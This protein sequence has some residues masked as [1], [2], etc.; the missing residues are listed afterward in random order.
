MRLVTRSPLLRALV[1]SVLFGSVIL[2]LLPAVE[3]DSSRVDRLIRQLGSEKFEERE[4]AS[5]ALQAIGEPALTSL[6]RAAT[7]SGDA[8]VRRRAKRLGI[9]LAPAPLDCTGKDG[10][11]PS[12]VRRDQEA[13]ARFLGRRAEEPVEVAGGVK[14]TFV[15]VPPGKFLMGSPKAGKRP[16]QPDPN[17]M[18]FQERL[19]AADQPD[20]SD[21][22]HVVTLTEPFDL[23]KT[24][25]TQ[26][27]YATLCPGNPSEFKGVDRPVEM[28]SWEE[29]KDWAD[30]VTRERK[31]SHQYRLPTEAEWEYACRGGRPFSRPFGVGDGQALSSRQ[32]NFDGNYPAGGAGKGRFL[33][34]TCAVASY[35]GNALGL[36]D[37]HGNVWEWCADWYGEY[38]DGPVTNPTGPAG[39]ESRVIRGG[40]W[41]HDGRRCRPEFRGHGMPGCRFNDLGFRVARTVPSWLD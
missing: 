6:R 33:N 7:N 11:S 34:A 40:S 1:S 18:T 36:L 15:L 8:E 29:A 23:G 21:V 37:M 31:D 10:I 26:A 5:R 35:P 32:A 22:Q 14:M 30:R 27:Q 4:A 20:W 41:V 9:A 24:E 38:P 12:Q 25:L 28:V 39:G 13:W 3:S 19:R 17:E 16:V 2:P